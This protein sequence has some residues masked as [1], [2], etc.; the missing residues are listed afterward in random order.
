M[1]VDERGVLDGELVGPLSV[2]ERWLEVHRLGR[3][4]VACVVAHE[5]GLQGHRSLAALDLLV[6]PVR[7]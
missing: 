3:A 1:Q 6:V 4:L 7:V 2:H 5:G